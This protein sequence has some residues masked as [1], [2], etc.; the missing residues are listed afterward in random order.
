MGNYFNLFFF[1]YSSQ[2]PEFKLINGF[3]WIC[4]S[5]NL[6]NEIDDNILLLKDCTTL[7]LSSNNITSLPKEFNLLK[8]LKCLRISNNRIS[9]LPGIIH[10]RAKRVNWI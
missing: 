1:P 7:D 10:E 2:I 4:L 9:M 5:H 3:K 6:L 8:S